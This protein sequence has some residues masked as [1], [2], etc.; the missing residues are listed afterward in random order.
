MAL[1]RVF[2]L[3]CNWFLNCTS[4]LKA[5]FLVTFEDAQ[6]QLN[7]INLSLSSSGTPGTLPGAENPYNFDTQDFFRGVTGKFLIVN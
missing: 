3:L 7:E 6:H 2:E 4:F 1:V 5:I